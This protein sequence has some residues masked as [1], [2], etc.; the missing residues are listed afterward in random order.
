MRMI[1]TVQY[2][3]HCQAGWCGS[4]RW[5]VLWSEHPN[6][7]RTCWHNHS[8]SHFYLNFWALSRPNLRCLKNHSTPEWYNIPL[9]SFVSFWVHCWNK[10]SIYSHRHPRMLRSGSFNVSH[11]HV[12]ITMLITSQLVNLD[13]E[14]FR[15]IRQVPEQLP[16]TYSVHRPL[17]CTLYM[18]IITGTGTCA[19]PGRDRNSNRTLT[20]DLLHITTVILPH[21][22][23]SS[24]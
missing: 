5:S 18:R 4:E 24:A 12:D 14:E 16:P 7:G 1:L 8:T 11:R 17:Q 19:F 20:Q 10:L 15:R 23:R 13:E 22:F 2:S 6:R 9:H 21:S 3:A